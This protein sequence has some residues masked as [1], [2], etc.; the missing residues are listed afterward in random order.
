[1]SVVLKRHNIQV[2]EKTYCFFNPKCCDIYPTD[3]SPF[4]MPEYMPDRCSD[5]N[6]KLKSWQRST[7]YVNKWE[8][9]F[10]KNFRRWRFTKMLHITAPKKMHEDLSKVPEFIQ[11]DE[12]DGEPLKHA[13]KSD[14]QKYYREELKKRFK[15]LRR[16]KYWQKMVDGGQWFYECPISDSGIANPHLHIVLVGPK[17]IDQ[18]K[19]TALLVKHKLG[20]ISKFTSPKNKKGHVQKMTYWKN[21]K[22][23][24]NKSAVRR[25]L[26]YV[27]AYC[28]KEQQADGKNNAF[29]GGL[30]KKSK[31]IRH[32]A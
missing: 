24:M 20:E 25:A 32:N 19:L 31:K 13:T 16:E 10:H 7:K 27:Q 17:K 4:D 23:V 14:Y 1:M 11:K 21:K 28:K 30:H 9:A 5:C 22:L 18:E 15:Q 12:R 6:K 29:F 26:G 8:K 2:K 3:H